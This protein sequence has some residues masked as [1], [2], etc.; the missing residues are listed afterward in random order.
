MAEIR[1]ACGRAT[2]YTDSLGQLWAAD[3]SSTGGGTFTSGDVIANTPDQPLFQAERYAIGQADFSYLIPIP[4]GIYTLRLGFAEIFFGSAGQRVFN[5]FA[6]NTQVLFSYDIVADAGG[7]FRA[8]VKSSAITVVDGIANVR[9]ASIT[10]NAKI[11][12]IEIV[13]K[14]SVPP[15]SFL[16]LMAC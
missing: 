6:Q 4:N 11:S 16:M 15:P 5:V 12:N 2:T 14:T 8:V 3:N 13:P 10:D 9:L 7:N 1:I